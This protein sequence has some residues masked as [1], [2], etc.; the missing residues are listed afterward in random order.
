MSDE[1]PFLAFVD[2]NIWLYAFIEDAQIVACALEAQVPVLYSE[3]LQ[4]KQ[5]VENQLQILN[6]FIDS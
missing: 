4:D 5:L 1:P 6:P 2:T 3:D